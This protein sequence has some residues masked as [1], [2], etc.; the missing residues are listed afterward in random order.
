MCQNY[1]KANNDDLA[2]LGVLDYQCGISSG[3]LLILAADILG[4][5]HYVILTTWLDAYTLGL[6][7]I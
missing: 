4:T 2:S 3:D 6:W 5:G 1:L 7:Y